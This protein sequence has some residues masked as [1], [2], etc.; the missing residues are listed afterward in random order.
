M[1]IPDLESNSLKGLVCLKTKTNLT[2]PI[3]TYNNVI[4]VQKFT[5]N[6]YAIYMYIPDLELT[7]LKWL[8]CHKN[9]TKPNQTNR[10]I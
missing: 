4:N 2:K 1:Y 5:N 10:Y 3:G 6:I 8:V 7:Y 9:Q